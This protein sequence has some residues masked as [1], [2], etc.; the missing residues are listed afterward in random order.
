MSKQLREKRKKAV[1]LLNK[2][3]TEILKLP[4]FSDFQID[5]ENIRL[6]S[7]NLEA[8]IYNYLFRN[9]N[10]RSNTYSQRYLAI[11]Q[12]IDPEKN[13]LF[14]KRIL[15]GEWSFDYVSKVSQLNPELIEKIK[16]SIKNKQSTE[17]KAKTKGTFKCGK[18]KSWYTTYTQAQ[19]RSADEPMTTFVVCL[20]CNNR[21]KFS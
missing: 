16:N 13:P 12:N 4:L 6:L 2:K 7:R 18:C 1:V 10:V 20:N 19:T 8:S 5:E 15:T 11:V 17:K 3:L 14:L 21:W 9:D